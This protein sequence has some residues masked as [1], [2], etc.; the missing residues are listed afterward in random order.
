[1]TIKFLQGK[2]HKFAIIAEGAE[3][4]SIALHHGGPAYFWKESEIS[5]IYQ[6][7]IKLNTNARLFGIMSR[8]CGVGNARTESL[9]LSDD[10]VLKRAEDM[11]EMPKTDIVVAHS[12][13]IIPVLTAV[14]EGFISPKA[15]VLLSPNS[16]SLGEQQ[17]WVREKSKKFPASYA[18]FKHFIKSHW[19]TYASSHLPPN[20]EED[21]F[22]HWGALYSRLPNSSVKTQAVLS[23]LC[24][25]MADTLKPMKEIQGEPYT[26]A[27]H[28]LTHPENVDGN[29]KKMFL[30]VGEIMSNWMK[31]NFVFDY[32]FLEKLQSYEFK[33]PIYIL[34]GEDDHIS[35]P[36]QVQKLADIIKAK[37]CKIVK[38]AGHLVDSSIGTG[39]L[40][41]HTAELL[42]E[43]VKEVE[44]LSA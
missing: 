20:F 4:P 44:L 43:V 40:A 18:L 14:M 3:G 31:N 28:L 12:L 29:L 9:N 22:M 41:K 17:F 11:Q 8:G 38:G 27:H 39:E 33:M 34:S 15:L 26:L 32:P 10:S 36:Q 42:A 1:M 5:D 13:G 16:A 37:D 2:K 35:P 6:H 23:M 30:N 24:F 25:H 19:V 7:M 21:I